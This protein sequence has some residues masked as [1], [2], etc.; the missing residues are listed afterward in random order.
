MKKYNTSTFVRCFCA[1]LIAIFSSAIAF[2]AQSDSNDDSVAYSFVGAETNY[3]NSLDALFSKI[4]NDTTIVIL[5][6]C[7]LPSS[8]ITITNKI[9]LY[10]TNLVSLSPSS[11][12]A[13]EITNDAA[14]N[15]S[16]I[17]ISSASLD[18]TLDQTLFNVRGGNL[19][20]NSGTTISNLCINNGN[21]VKIISGGSFNMLDGSTIKKCKMI[22]ES[23]S[24]GAVY[25]VRSDNIV[26]PDSTFNFLG[27]TISECSS[28]NYGG[29][30]YVGKNAKVVLEGSATAIDNTAHDSEKSDIYFAINPP[31]NPLLSIENEFTGKIG[32]YYTGR[33]SISNSFAVVSTSNNTADFKEKIINSA[34]KSLYATLLVDGE[35]LTLIWDQE[36]IDDSIKPLPDENI[37]DAEAKVTNGSTPKYYAKIS[38]ALTI[39]NEGERIELLKDA[40]LSINVTLGAEKVIFDG[41]GHTLSRDGNFVID[42]G[43]KKSLLVTNIVLDGSNKSGRFFNVK[44]GSLIFEDGAILTNVIGNTSDSDFV[45]PIV[46]WGGSFTMN[47]GEIRNCKN[48]YTP[49]PGGPLT[50]GALVM[51]GGVAFLN[52]GLITECVGARAGGAG[53]YNRSTAYVNGN[54]TILTNANPFGAVCNLVIQDLSKMIVTSNIIGK[55][56]C[57][58][59]FLADTNIAAY[60]D[61]SFASSTTPSNLVA[62]ALRFRH[63]ILDVKAVP[64]TNGTDTLFV[65]R[66]ALGENANFKTKI[67]GVEKIYEQVLFPIEDPDFVECPPFAF[68]SIT[69]SEN[70]TEWLMTIKPVKEYCKYTF[71]AS[72]DLK[73]WEVVYKTEALSKDSISPNE[74]YIFK[75]EMDGDKRFWRAEGKNGLK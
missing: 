29:A 63:D 55:I 13:F 59:G 11:T 53:F 25:L 7:Y 45:A 31:D 3:Y 64:V 17:T 28:P 46:V 49:E 66:T 4:T 65:W 16:N 15:I 48:N 75:N 33:T 34:D 62:S 6:D 47:G 5:K 36:T 24:G 2:A 26:G 21:V 23:N 19:T 69:E 51:S 57:Y 8:K 14:L 22:E 37:G 58:D 9:E 44:G 56:G 60:V 30:I 32:V 20:F 61:E 54:F 35:T 27:G 71:Y 41:C 67:D 38:D 39:A 42:I 10:S 74:E 52:D 1:I 72:S 12:S 40:Y 43:E 50:A 70:K 73:N 18:Q 68:T